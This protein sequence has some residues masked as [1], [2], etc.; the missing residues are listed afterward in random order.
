M[1]KNKRNK[2]EKMIKEERENNKC[3]MIRNGKKIRINK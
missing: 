2:M 3:N 1:D